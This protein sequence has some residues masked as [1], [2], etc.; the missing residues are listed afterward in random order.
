MADFL[1][2]PK[3]PDHTMKINI[4]GTLSKDLVLSSDILFSI[5]VDY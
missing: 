4:G 2:N 5:F 3:V 1:R